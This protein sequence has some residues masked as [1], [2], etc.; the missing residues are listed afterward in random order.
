[1]KKISYIVPSILK[2]DNLVTQLT[3]I[4]NTDC[5]GEIIIIN[6]SNGYKLPDFICNA[7]II[8]IIPS[9]PSFCN[10]GWNIGVEKSTQDYVVL[11]TDDLE[12]DSNILNIITSNIN[13]I[14]PFGIIGMDYKFISDEY[15]KVENDISFDQVNGEREYG[16]GMMMIM[17][18]S[19]FVKIPDGLKHW[20]GDDFLYYSMIEKDLKNYIM[21]SKTFKLKTKVGSM[22]GSS[23]TIN[24]IDEDTRNWETHYKGP[25]KQILK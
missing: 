3:S 21:R 23:E 4:G 5:V 18:K 24:R 22:S 25:F 10:G 11:S 15:S 8:E 16:F 2:F 14:E 13:K 9:E 7:P 6:N 17:N 20:Y 19:N 1:M 12:F